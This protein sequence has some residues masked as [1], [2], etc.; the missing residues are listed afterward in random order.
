[1][2]SDTDTRSLIVSDY[3]SFYK[4]KVQKDDMLIPLGSEDQFRLKEYAIELINPLHSL[5][6]LTVFRI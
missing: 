5:N 2:A 4:S 3:V 1:M 6:P